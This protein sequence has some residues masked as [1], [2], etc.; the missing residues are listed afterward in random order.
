MNQNT[1]NIRIKVTNTSDQTTDNNHINGEQ[2]QMPMKRARTKNVQSQ[3]DFLQE[4]NDQPTI[5]LPSK[6]KR[7]FK[8]FILIALVI[9]VL[10]GSLLFSS[11]LQTR[12]HDNSL[13]HALNKLNLWGQLSSMISNTSAEDDDDRTNFII[14]GMGGIGHDGPFLT[15][16]IIFVSMRDSTS[17]LA[18]T[19]IPRDLVVKYTDSYYPKINEVYTIG[20]KNDN[21]PAQFASD[22]ISDNFGQDIDYHIVLNFD[23]FGEIIDILGDITI[24]VERSFIDTQYPTNDYEYQ[25]VEFIEGIQKMDG[26]TALKYV[27]SRHGNNGEGS[28]FARSRRQQKV[29]FAIKNKILSYQTLLN[30]YKISRL[31]SSITKHLTTNI[32]LKDALSLFEELKEINLDEALQYTIDDAPNGLLVADISE[33]GAYILKPKNGYNSLQQFINELF[34]Y[35]D[36]ADETAII[37]IQNGTTIPGL[38]YSLTQEMRGYNLD[39]ASYQNAATQ[40]YQRT[41]IYDTSNGDKPLTTELLK[42]TIPYAIMTSTIPSHLEE[43]IQNNEIDFIVIIGQDRVYNNQL[44]QINE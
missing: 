43:T 4:Y 17:Q 31:Y 37:S 5:T 26:N 18:L 38:A 42:K 1:N 30:P 29:L 8:S 33:D 6:G 7:I 20:R 21:N 44:D 14:M 34:E 24:D 2:K 15:D 22:I 13:T 25:T 19:S 10:F 27:R 11:Y 32:S 35:S 23:G 3:V 28:D 36:T 39:I 9:V 41:I 40:D 16:T 12:Q